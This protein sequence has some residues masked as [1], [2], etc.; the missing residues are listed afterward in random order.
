MTCANLIFPSTHRP[1]LLHRPR[2]D[3]TATLCCC[4]TRSIPI[5]LRIEIWVLSPGSLTPTISQLPCRFFQI[6]FHPPLLR[7]RRPRPCPIP[8]AWYRGLLRHSG[9]RCGLRCP[10]SSIVVVAIGYLHGRSIG[11][12]CRCSCWD[13]AC[14]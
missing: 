3:P 12:W 2:S 10:H 13:R 6:S 11:F 9:R 14:T 8:S 1:L 5:R 7:R 4:S